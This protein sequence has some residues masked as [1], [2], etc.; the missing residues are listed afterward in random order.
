[1]TQ[2]NKN[3][4]AGGQLYL[5][6]AGLFFGSPVEGFS[7][8]LAGGMYSFSAL[9]VITS[10]EGKRVGE[11][12][13]PLSQVEGFIASMPIS[14]C[15]RF[16][17]LLDNL[18]QDRPN[19]ALRNGASLSFDNPNIMGIL[20]ITPDSFSDGGDFSDPDVAIVAAKAMV[21]DGADIIDVGG[22]STRPGANP[23]SESEEGKR[24]L[25]IFKALLDVSIPK[26]IDSR[27]AGV[28]AAALAAGADI[29]NDVT[30]L[31]FDTDSL[32]V[33]T[34]SKAPVIL[35]HSK[36]SPQSMQD[37]PKYSD[38]VL[39]VFDYLEAR[40]DACLAAGI[41][42]TNIWL[43]P[44]IGF[45]KNLDH[46]L[47][48]LKGIGFLHSL[49]C[50]LMLGVSRKRFIGDLTGES[51]AKYRVAGSI[52][53]AFHGISQGVQVVRVHDVSATKQAL[54]VFVSIGADRTK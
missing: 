47:L 27:R 9:E 16:N 37:S 19:L 23:V 36:G 11:W 21:D 39:E 38:V 44:G 20:N 46:N 26:S 54:E 6:P 31:E 22:E 29:I 48:L 53:A 43:D 7:L 30:A 50:V 28:M 41:S 35:M 33:A 34:R 15:D 4:P 17:E 42:K 14:Y 40:R 49:G 51:K 3:F 12:T 13:L 10:C 25:P 24:V 32:D 45:G 2:I 8:T 1:M 52:S 5:A 18:T